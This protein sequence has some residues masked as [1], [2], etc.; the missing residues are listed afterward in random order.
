MTRNRTAAVRYAR[1]L[2]DISLENGDLRTA[3]SDLD[4]FA[5]LVNEHETLRKVLAQYNGKNP[6][7]SCRAPPD[8]AAVLP[9]VPGRTFVLFVSRL[10]SACLPPVGPPKKRAIINDLRNRFRAVSPTVTRLLTML[11]EEAGHH[12]R[13]AQ[14]FP[15]GFPDRGRLGLLPDIV[16]FYRARVIEHL[17]VVDAQ[18]TTAQPLS[19]EQTAAMRERLATA[20]AGDVRLTTVVDPEILGGVV[21]RIGSTVYDGSVARHLE[22]MRQTLLER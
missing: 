20:G 14:P 16:R 10:P 9:V 15:G 5:Q 2:F 21:T 4:Q 22:R 13:P 8:R 6:Q 7:L 1:A 17:G 11:A 3:E 18:V 19:P 12:Q